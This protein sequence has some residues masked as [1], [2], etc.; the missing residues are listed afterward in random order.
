MHR[1]I[2]MDN[3]L[4]RNNGKFLEI[5]IINFGFSELYCPNESYKKCGTPGFVAPEIFFTNQYTTKIDV[6]SLGVIFY[7]LVYG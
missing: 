7:M 1:D 6:F 3:I 4:V 2:K 5:K